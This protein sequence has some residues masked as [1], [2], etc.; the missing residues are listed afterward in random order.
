M[1]SLT[2]DRPWMRPGLNGSC[3]C[4]ER[5]SGRNRERFRAGVA[6]CRHIGTEYVPSDVSWVT[7]E[8]GHPRDTRAL[9]S[10]VLLC[11]PGAALG[12]EVV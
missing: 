12:E 2:P 1:I 6:T 5:W 4:M 11:N 8:G 9:G 7:G 10:W 3:V